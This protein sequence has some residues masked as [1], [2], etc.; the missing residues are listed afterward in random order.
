MYNVSHPPPLA[1]TR[2]GNIE[3]FARRGC[4][5][6]AQRERENGGTAGTCAMVSTGVSPIDK[7]LTPEIRGYFRI[8]GRL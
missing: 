8:H 4:R 2:S 1:G 3:E 7:R 5:A 6:S